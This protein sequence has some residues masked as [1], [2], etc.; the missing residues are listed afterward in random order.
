MGNHYFTLLLHYEEDHKSASGSVS[1]DYVN[2][3][4]FEKV[5]SYKVFMQKKK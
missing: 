2:I 5:Y 1:D 4:P 3:G